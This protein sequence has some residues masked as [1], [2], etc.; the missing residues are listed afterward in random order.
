MKKIISLTISILFLFLS[1]IFPASARDERHEQIPE[2]GARVITFD[3]GDYL[4]ISEPTVRTAT[5]RK[6]AVTEINADR[7][8]AYYDSDDNLEWKYTLYATFEYEY[9][10]SSV[11]TNAYYVQNIYKG[12]WTFSNGAAYTSANRATGTGRYVEKYLFITV[13]TIEVSL[14]M[15]CD[16]FGNVTS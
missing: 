10:V 13:N 15:T 3:S 8:T 4:I 1:V 2:G 9:G 14:T 12:N 6:G 7:F 5:C 11:C 16:V